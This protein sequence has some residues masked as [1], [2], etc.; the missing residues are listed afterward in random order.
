MN[1][2]L[3]A[4]DAPCN[5]NFSA[6]KAIR[7]RCTVS[8]RTST[9][10]ENITEATNRFPQDILRVGIRN[11][12]LIARRD[13]LASTPFVGQGWTKVKCS[14][15]LA[16]QHESSGSVR[17]L[18]TYAELRLERG[19]AWS[20]IVRLVPPRSRNSSQGANGWVCIL[21]IAYQR[22]AASPLAASPAPLGLHK[23]CARFIDHSCGSLCNCVHCFHPLMLCQ[24]C[25][26]RCDVK[27]VSKPRHRFL[28]SPA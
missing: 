9:A 17:P 18:R 1:S 12:P 5:W 15:G 3:M 10:R 20:Q 4:S 23:L 8:S 26:R 6:P 16:S 11:S 28:R 2:F 13:R 24:L 19:A 14:D 21:E 22:L 25:G 27:I 7:S